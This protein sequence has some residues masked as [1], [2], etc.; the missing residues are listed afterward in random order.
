M[1]TRGWWH[2]FAGCPEVMSVSQRA[3]ASYYDLVRP[4]HARVRSRQSPTRHAISHRHHREPRR[5]LALSWQNHSTMG[6]ERRLI[7]G[8]G[9]GVQVRLT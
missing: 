9:D 4:P 6:G 1:R 3:D 7:V 5:L 2:V 8:E